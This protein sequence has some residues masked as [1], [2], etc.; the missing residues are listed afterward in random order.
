M[1]APCH[2]VPGPNFTMRTFHSSSSE[3]HA[4][5]IFINFLRFPKRNLRCRNAMGYLRDKSASSRFGL[6]V[7]ICAFFRL[8]VLMGKWQISRSLPVTASFSQSAFRAAP[9]MCTIWFFL[10]DWPASPL[11]KAEMGVVRGRGDRLHPCCQNT[12]NI[13][14][15]ARHG[16][17]ISSRPKV[18]GHASQG[19][20]G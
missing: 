7:K 11:H 13:V 14:S 1:R 4:Y 17:N 9:L 2:G 18:T 15:V 3:S 19:G 12:K 5:T 10:R 8:P 6:N 20:S 16:Q